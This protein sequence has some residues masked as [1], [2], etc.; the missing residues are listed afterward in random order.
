ME[1]CAAVR[2]A[3]VDEG[4]SHHEAT[5]RFGTDHRTVAWSCPMPI[6]GS[7][8][9]IPGRRR[10]PSWMTMSAPSPSPFGAVWQ[11]D[12]GA[13]QILG[14]GERVRTRA[15]THLRTTCSATAST[16]LARVTTRG[17]SRS[18]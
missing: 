9:R 8:R 13:V 7:S 15:F 2:L 11:Y 5:R 14:D 4:L 18:W 6:S 1:L 16:D 10:R 17:K 12:P 3:A